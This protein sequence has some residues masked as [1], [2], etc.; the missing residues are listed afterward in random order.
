VDSAENWRPSIVIHPASAYAFDHDDLAALVRA[1]G[2]EIGIMADQVEV[3]LH[4]LYGNGVADATVV[5]FI[6]DQAAR[7]AIDAILL[8]IAAWGRHWLKRKRATNPDTPPI[9]A[10]ILGADGSVLREVDVPPEEG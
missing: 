1:V 2:P 7:T 10:R 3:R 9:R 8:G 4:Y 6:L 5:S